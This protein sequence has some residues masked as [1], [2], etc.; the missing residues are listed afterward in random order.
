VIEGDSSSRWR[1]VRANGEIRDS[2]VAGAG[3]PSEKSRLVEP[4]L[5]ALD[6]NG[7]VCSEPDVV[8]TERE[9]G[10]M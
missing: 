1:C 6:V 4:E 5:D 9:A 3:R 10:I 7:E 8:L 2:G